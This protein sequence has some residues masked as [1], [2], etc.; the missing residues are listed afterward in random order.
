MPK[1]QTLLVLMVPFALLPLWILAHGDERRYMRQVLRSLLRSRER[2]DAFF[3]CAENDSDAASCSHILH[4]VAEIIREAQEI[5]PPSH[6]SA[7]AHDLLNEAWS[8]ELMAV[9]AFQEWLSGRDTNSLER[10]LAYVR[11]AVDKKQRAIEMLD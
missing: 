4:D 10:G 5:D 8:A 1:I 11:V 9:S 7:E 3:D 2:W 6:D